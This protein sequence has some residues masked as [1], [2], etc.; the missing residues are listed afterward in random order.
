MP[1]MLSRLRALPKNIRVGVVGIGNIGRGIVYQVDATPGMECVAIADT[2]LEHAAAWAERLGRVYTVVETAADMNDTIRQGLLAVCADGLLVSS[3]DQVDVL[4]DASTSGP[5]FALEAI[6]HRKHVV[7]MNCEADL[8]YGPYLLSQAIK[9]LV[10]YTSADGDQHTVLKRLMHD[11][12]LWGFKTVMAGNMKGFLDRYS[13]PTTILPE[14]EKRFMDA[15][16]CASYTDGTKL[17]VEMALIANAIGARTAVPG[18]LGPRVPNIYN[19]FDHFNLAELWDGHTPLVDYTLGTSP[20]GG[21]FIVGYNDHPHQVETLSWYPCHLGPGPF[22]VFHRPY[23]LGHI[24]IA[25]CIAEVALDGYALLQPIYGFLTNVYTYAKK[26]L[27]AGDALDGIGG[28]TAYGLIENC[29]DNREH[30]GLPICLSENVTLRRDISIDQK[31]LLEDVIYDPAEPA[32]EL[33]RLA[34]LA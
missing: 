22:Y 21:V 20:S 30:P 4:V 27:R 8:M 16:M 29:V 23:H 12:E 14:A 33:F 32:F 24:E 9:N 28:Y 1:D 25:A 31:I 34:Q 15:K 17:C 26:D 10:V 6:S 18:M 5:Q 7:M 11:T 19:V 13:N 2:R 3:C